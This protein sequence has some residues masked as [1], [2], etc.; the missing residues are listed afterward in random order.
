M[1]FGI[2]APDDDSARILAA[3]YLPWVPYFLTITEVKPLCGPH[4]VR[5]CGKCNPR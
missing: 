1:A 5:Q 3:R 4:Q 2:S